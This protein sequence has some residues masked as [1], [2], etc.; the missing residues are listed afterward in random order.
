MKRIGLTAFLVWIGIG[1]AVFVGVAMGGH[2]RLGAFGVLPM[3][4]L[5]TSAWWIAG[6]VAEDR[7]DG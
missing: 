1:L 2:V 4:L 6:A 7:Q 3:A 5:V